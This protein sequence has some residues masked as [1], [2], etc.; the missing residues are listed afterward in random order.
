MQ[1]RVPSKL[2]TTEGAKSKQKVVDELKVPDPPEEK[3][4]AILEEEDEECISPEE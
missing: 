2:Y 1:H 3:A 4:K